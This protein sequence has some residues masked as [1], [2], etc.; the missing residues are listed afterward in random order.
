[1]KERIR[2]IDKGWVGLISCVVLFG[3][4]SFWIGFTYFTGTFL[5]KVAVS[6]LMWSAVNILI[7]MRN[8]FLIGRCL[9]RARKRQ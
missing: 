1:V 7:I 4:V 8:L 5:H 2:R 6:C 3:V 9:W